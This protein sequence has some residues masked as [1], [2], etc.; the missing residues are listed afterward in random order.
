MQ[1]KSIFLFEN[2]SAKMVMVRY[3]CT[4]YTLYYWTW[5]ISYVR[6]VAASSLNKYYSLH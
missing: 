3:S 6:H 5:G 2:S 1:D 4:W